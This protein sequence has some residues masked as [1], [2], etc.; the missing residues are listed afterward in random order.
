MTKPKEH[1]KV[2]ALVVATVLLVF[3]LIGILNAVGQSHVRAAMESERAE[4]AYII[5]AGER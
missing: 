2:S 1:R 3:L 5:N 4:E